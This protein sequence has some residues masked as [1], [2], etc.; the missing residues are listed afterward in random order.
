MTSHETCWQTLI[1]FYTLEASEMYHLNLKAIVSDRRWWQNCQN[2]R[3]CIAYYQE[4]RIL[5]FQGNLL[6]RFGLEK[7]AESLV[8][9]WS[10]LCLVFGWTYSKLWHTKNRLACIL[11]QDWKY[12]S[13]LWLDMVLLY[14]AMYGV[15][16][17]KCLGLSGIWTRLDRGLSTV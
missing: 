12:S 9:P 17:S 15:G 13:L 3:L 14:Y 2:V 4:W 11:D 10:D 7:N 6:F 16:P 5:K 8:V 1:F